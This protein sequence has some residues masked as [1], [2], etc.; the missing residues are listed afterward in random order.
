MRVG[1]KVVSEQVCSWS[2]IK[3][4]CWFFSLVLLSNF[5]LVNE[6]STWVPFLGIA[7]ALCHYI[8]LPQRDGCLNRLEPH[9]YP[10]AIEMDLWVLSKEV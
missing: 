5:H 4:I 10:L 8:W 3:N 9:L 6:G 2:W 1:R 7:L